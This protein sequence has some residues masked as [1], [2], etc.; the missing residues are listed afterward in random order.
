VTPATDPATAALLAWLAASGVDFRLEAATPFPAF[1]STVLGSRDLVLRWYDPDPWVLPL[2][3]DIVAREVAALGV[4]AGIAG[5]PAPSLVAWSEATPS[6]VLMTRLPGTTELRPPDVGA[7][8][9]LLAVLHAAPPGALAG[10]HS[11]RGYHQGHAWPRPA[12]WRDAVLWERVVAAAAAPPLVPS[13]LIHRDFHPDNVLWTD[14]RISGVV[15]WANAC[16]GPAAMDVAHFRV[17]LATLHGP[18]VA[19]QLLPG[20]PA[21]D[22]EAALG[23]LEWGPGLDTWAGPW[24]AVAA[25]QAR[26]WLES[27]VARAVAALG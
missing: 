6:A 1:T 9:D 12:W 25:T 2:E 14:G 10:F 18:A 21:W 26:A 15:D 3:P 19:D 8:R 11:Y 13:V 16:V 4:V 24:P 20:E 23:F 5:V 7:L 22:I 17:N 27:F